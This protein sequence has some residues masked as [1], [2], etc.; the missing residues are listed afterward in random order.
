VRLVALVALVA[1]GGTPRTRLAKAGDEHDDGA[2]LLARASTNLALGEP[3]VTEAP[4]RGWGGATNGGDAYSGDA[5]GGDAYG[6]DTY[7]S[8]MYGG[9]TYGSWTIPTWSYSAPNR[10]PKYN[11][12]AGLSGAVEGT[13]TWTGTPP[14]KVATTCGTLDNP[15]VHVGADRGVSGTVVYIEKVAIGRPVAYFSRPA[16]IG[17]L[18]AKHGCVLAPAAQLVTPLPAS[19]AIHGDA[20][21]AKVR[22][23]PPGGAA[24]SYE[25]QEG[26]RAMIELT[27]GV[28]RVDGDDGKLG[29]AWVLAIETPYYAITDD[30]GH[31]RIDELASGTYD[32]TFW[33]A[34]VATAGE[35][36]VINY[37]APLVAH[38]TVKIEAGKTAKVAVSLSGR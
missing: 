25:L 11:V 29:A 13:V 27:S 36:G 30:T 18:V 31:F 37:G 17:G 32:V 14:P 16:S 26:G 34:P 1:C 21:R 9:A 38:R 24:K 22:V 19:L 35:G 5:Y 7:G 12:V 20:T 33:Q 4:E 6:G 23:T 3:E 2:G 8:N 15:S 28:T 10:M